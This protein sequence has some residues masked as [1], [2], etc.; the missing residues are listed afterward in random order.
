MNTIQI[1]MIRHNRHRY[2]TSGDFYQLAPG[3]WA[4]VVSQMKGDCRFSCILAVHELVEM[5]CTQ[6]HNISERRITAWDKR[7]LRTHPDSEPGDV[8]GCPYG[9][10]HKFAEKVERMLCR[11][12]GVR[13]KDYTKA[14]NALWK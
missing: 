7:C 6:A 9:K 4:I 3:H 12:M 5:L 11:Q 13:W 14:L 1:A 2:P 10:Q 8:P